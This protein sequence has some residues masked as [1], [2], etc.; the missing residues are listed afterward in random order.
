MV[1][2]GRSS[3]NQTEKL[4]ETQCGGSGVWSGFCSLN[5][6]RNELLSREKME[7]AQRRFLD[8][9]VVCVGGDSSYSIYRLNMGILWSGLAA[10]RV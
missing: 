1:R 9:V 8:G 10:E 3:E 4:F 2:E 7:A 6:L 5:G